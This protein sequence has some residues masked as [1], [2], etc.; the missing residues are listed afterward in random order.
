[1]ATTT[2]TASAAQAPVGLGT[3]T[4]F[5]VLAGSTVTNTGPSVIERRPRRQ[6][7][8]RGRGFPPG[9]RQQRHHPR[10]DAVALQAQSD[11]TTAYNDAAGRIPAV[12]DQTDPDVGGQT[13][14]AGVTR[15]RAMA[16]SGTVTLDAQGDPAAVFIFQAGSTLITASNSTV[17]LI[18]GAQACHVVLAG[19]RA[20]PPSGTGTHFVGT[21]M[22]LTSIDHADRGQPPRP[23]AGQERRGDPGHQHDHPFRL[24][25]AAPH[26]STPPT[27]TATPTVPPRPRT[28]ALP[29]RQPPPPRHRPLAPDVRPAPAPRRHRRHGG[30]G[31]N[32]GTAAVKPGDHG[33]GG[34]GGGGGGGVRQ[35]RS[36]RS[37]VGPGGGTPR[38]PTGHPGTGRDDLADTQR[39][40]WSLMGCCR[41]PEP[42]EPVP[43]LEGLRTAGTAPALMESDARPPRWRG[44]TVVLLLCRGLLPRAVGRRLLA[45]AVRRRDADVTSPRLP[46]LGSGPKSTATAP[47]RARTS[48]RDQHPGHRRHRSSRSWA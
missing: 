13:L 27:T 45:G 24:H 47:V 7:R 23:R 22:A 5:A 34:G 11:L 19:R 40:P 48:G 36:R 15:R 4:S 37:S 25:H 18:G 42:A 31:G 28:R 3:A 33:S 16:L 30:S 17:A 44:M 26:P 6:P 21:V 10:R 20:P 2:V 8:Q 32:G 12:V 14:V 35:R 38:I 39:R 9:P 1:M 46:R 41:W 43:R 29:P